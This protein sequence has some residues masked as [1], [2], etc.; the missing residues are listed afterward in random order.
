[1]FDRVLDKRLQDQSRDFGI[2]RVRIDLVVDRQAILKTRLLDLEVL[3]QE[4]EL[5]VERHAGGIGAR[6]RDAQQVAQATDHAVGGLRMRVHQR[7]DRVQG[8]EQEM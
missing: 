8:V 2:E 1:M 7:R 6:K 3:L 5:L 4:L